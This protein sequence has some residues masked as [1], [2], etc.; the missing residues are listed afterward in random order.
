VKYINPKTKDVLLLLTTGTVIAASFLMPGAPLL[1][2]PLTTRL[3]E[4]EEKEWKKYNPYRLKQMLKRLQKQKLV[5]VTSVNGEQL[6]TLSEKGKT[7]VLKFRLELL[8]LE[9]KK[10]DG[11]W[12]IVIYD[13]LSKKYNQRALFHRVLK[14][15]N[16]YQLQRSVY[17]TPYRCYDE[18]EYLRQVCGV[19]SEVLVLTISG[20]ENEQAYKEYFGLI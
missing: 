19:G 2:K 17:L 10:W 1:L 9:E 12:R 6:V 20:L 15:M 13:I 4:Q 3:K 18:V 8:S 16:F 7:K 11:K 14:Q 5:E